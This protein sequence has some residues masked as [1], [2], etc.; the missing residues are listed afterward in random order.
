MKVLG[1]R[2]RR[3]GGRILGDAALQIVEPSAGFWR[4]WSLGWRLG[5]LM[6]GGVVGESVGV[7]LGGPVGAAAR[8]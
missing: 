1:R 8:Q 6:A 3:G 2:C 4:V 7:A 5:S